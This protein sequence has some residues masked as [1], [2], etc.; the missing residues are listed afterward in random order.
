MLLSTPFAVLHVSVLLSF[1]VRTVMYT[2]LLHVFFVFG[3]S[4]C[5]ITLFISI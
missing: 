2:V 3:S 5:P 1:K 4:S